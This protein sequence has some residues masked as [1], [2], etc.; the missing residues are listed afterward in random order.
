MSRDEIK[1]EMTRLY[2]E[3]WTQHTDWHWARWFNVAQEVI[4]PI[5]ADVRGGANGQSLPR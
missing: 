3:G 5:A 1:R 4:A 2:R